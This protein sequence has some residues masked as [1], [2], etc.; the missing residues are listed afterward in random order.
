VPPDEA[1]CSQLLQ[2]FHNCPSGGH[3]RRNKTLKLICHHFIWNGIADDIQTY[4]TTCP[5]CQSKAIHHHQPYSKLE[6]LPIPTD[7]WNSPFK[8]ISLNWIT[9]LPPSFKN[10]QEYNSILTVM[11]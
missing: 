7:T 10:S 11:C 1:I 9:G 8:E 5:V 4:I 2:T 3:W 6:P